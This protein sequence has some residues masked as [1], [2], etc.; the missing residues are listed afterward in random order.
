MRR[1][2]QDLIGG[3]RV[4]SWLVA[5]GEPVV[6]VETNQPGVDVILKHVL[7]AHAAVS[8]G[9]LSAPTGGWTIHALGSPDYEA[10]LA[11]LGAGFA[12]AGAAC[13]LADYWR[14]DFVARRMGGREGALA[15]HHAA[16]F[17]A[18]T[19]FEAG[20]QAITYL[21]PAGAPV[22]MPHL[23]HLVGHVLR[24]QGW[25]RGFVDVHAAFVRYRGKGV[26]LIGP[27]RAGKTSLAMH[28]LSRGGELLGSDMAQIRAGAWGGVEAVSIPHMC[29]ITRETV[30][31]NAWLAAAIGDAY[32]GNDEYLSGPL[33][34][35]GKYELYDPS[36]DRIFQRSVG[37]SAMRLN[38][39]IF[40][41]FAVNIP[42]HEA[43]AAAQDEGGRRLISSIKTD[44]PLADWL[45]FDLSGRERGEAELEH[46]LTSGEAAIPAYDFRFGR[47]ASLK[48]DEIDALFD[49]I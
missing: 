28:L 24:L 46:R 10:Q 38:A 30:W 15:V 31:D 5:R 4:E 33:F 18:G 26:A 47:E 48:W 1:W 45:P 12:G 17:E 20:P 25:D 3:A 49:Q 8:P 23:E 11:K 14:G 44:R 27:R 13:D 2:R 7:G 32:D 22:F 34:S 39:I 36:L 6:Q 37:L 35:H 29:R 42:R 43:S 19:L 9:A 41:H 40:P 21:F 16:P